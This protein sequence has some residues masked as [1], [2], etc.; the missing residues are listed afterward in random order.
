MYPMEMTTTT[1]AIFAIVAAMGLIGVVAI[2]IMS[3]P[4]DVEAHGCNR[5]VPFNASQGR[6]F[7]H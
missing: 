3:V 7:G 6:C 2:A 1:L 5:S 4:E